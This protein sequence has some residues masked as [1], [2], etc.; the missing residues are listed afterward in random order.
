M[1]K[2]WAEV[3]ASPAYQSLAPEQQEEARSQYWNE[4]VAPNVPQSEHDQVRQAFDTDTAAT[5]RWP[6]RPAIDVDITGGT[7][8]SA[9]PPADFSGVTSSVDS[10]AFGNAPDGWKY[11]AGRDLA[12]GARSVIQGAGGLLGA[13]GGDAFN[14]YVANPI[15]RQLGLQ[16][17]GSYRDE[18]KALA[19][20][21]GLPQAQTA[22]DRVLGDVGEALT[23]T[24]LTLGAGAGLNALSSLGKAGGAPATNQ[25]ANL[26]TAQPGLQTVSTATGSGASSITRESGGSQGNQLLA[27]LA[28]GLGP[29]LATA[30]GAAALRGAVRGRSGEQMRNTLADFEALGATPSVGQASGNRLIQGAENVLAGGPTSAG[31]MGRFVERQAEDIGNGLGRMAD[32]MIPNASA[33]RAGRAIERG[34]EGFGRNVNANKRALYWQADR[35][36]PEATPVQVSNTQGVL[37]KLTTPQQGAKNTT[38]LL[39]NPRIAAIRDT[40]ELDTL[41]GGTIPYSALK[42]I[43]TNIGEQISDYSLSP[44]TPTRELKQLYAGLSRDMEAAAQA[45]GPEAVRAAKRANNYTRVAADRLEQVQRVIDKNGG[46]ERVYAAAMSGTRDGGTTLRAVMQSL[47]KEGQE[48]VT[49]AVIKRMGMASPGAQDASGEAFSAATFLTNWNKVSPEAKRAVFDRHGPRFSRDMDQLARVAENIKGGAKVFANPS[50]TANRAAAMTYGAS[51]VGGL[52]TGTLALPVGLGIGGNVTARL[53]T[54]PRVVRELANATTFPRN[55]VLST[56][57]NLHR[58]AEDEDDPDIAALADALSQNPQDQLQQTDAS[59]Q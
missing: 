28:G 51:L 30:G 52:F 11:G 35:Y 18:A 25:L 41:S 15:A 34:V 42:R 10:T 5:V 40:L 12:F 57:R 22:G 23:G 8:E 37:A 46:P 17:S 38:K 53:L 1:A 55:G 59:Q 44:D 21:I 2:K 16:E 4:V 58:I 32:N 43:R 19:D 6:E 54:N 48:A 33:E 14:N 39:I 9:T 7:P 45:Q 20:R 3:A 27:G 26:L 56:A 36:I 50:G 24:G 13:V 29:G 47:P 31:V 49:G